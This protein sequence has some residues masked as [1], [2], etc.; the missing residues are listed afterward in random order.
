MPKQL[1]LYVRLAWLASISPGLVKWAKFVFIFGFNTRGMGP[2]KHSQ[3]G[4]SSVN[5]PWSRFGE[6]RDG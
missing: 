1:L 3:R 6:L 4:L 2:T 5:K